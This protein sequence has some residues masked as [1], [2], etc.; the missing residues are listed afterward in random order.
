LKDPAV[1]RTTAGYKRSGT[2]F[3]YDRVRDCN[4]FFN[5][6]DPDTGVQ[7]L[8]SIVHGF[9][10]TAFNLMGPDVSYYLLTTF[11]YTARSCHEQ[12]S[13]MVAMDKT[14]ML[15]GTDGSG[16]A[17][18]ILW[19]LITVKRLEVEFSYGDKESF[20]LAFELAHA[21]YYFSPWGA[22]V[23]SSSP[24]KD[25]ETHTHTLCGSLAQYVPDENEVPEL[26]YVNGKLMLEPFPDGVQAL[27]NAA[28]NNLYNTNPTHVVPR[29]PRTENRYSPHTHFSECLVGLGSTPLPATFAAQLLRRRMFFFAVEMGVE[30]AL[31]QCSV[32]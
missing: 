29:Q 9:N 10:Y 1:L 30:Q 26:L 17:L 32:F 28:P 3:F 22:A 11:A 14:R 18:D 24:N 6:K 25:V 7:L 19:W 15:A 23:V 4:L 13:S 27:R 2:T 16:K 21:D 20:W 31:H 5:K 8:K 12:D